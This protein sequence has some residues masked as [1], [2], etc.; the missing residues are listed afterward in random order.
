MVLYRT[1]V[2]QKL[3]HRMISHNIRAINSRFATASEDPPA[4]YFM[5]SLV[6]CSG[7]RHHDSYGVLKKLAAYTL[8]P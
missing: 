3:I 2:I 1:L 7:W 4:L 5:I 6:T 8:R